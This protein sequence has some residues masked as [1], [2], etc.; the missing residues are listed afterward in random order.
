MVCSL[1]NVAEIVFVHCSS[2]ICLTLLWDLPV[3]EINNACPLKFV[4]FSILGVNKWFKGKTIHVD[5][6]QPSTSNENEDK[7]NLEL[8]I[9]VLCANFIF[10]NKLN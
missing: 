2:N 7:E 4:F 9:S 6:R 1:K 8:F 5:S 3:D 10:T